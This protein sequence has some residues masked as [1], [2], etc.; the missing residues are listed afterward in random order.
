MINYPKALIKNDLLNTSDWELWIFWHSPSVHNVR[1]QGNSGDSFY[2]DQ[3]HLYSA[4]V[5]DVLV[6]HQKSF[7]SETNKSYF[8]KVNIKSIIFLKYFI[9]EMVRNLI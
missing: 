8:I 6:F 1:G 4:F 7:V 2:N 5:A 3:Q 9:V